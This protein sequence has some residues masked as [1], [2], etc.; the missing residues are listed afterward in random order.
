MLKLASRNVPCKEI[1]KA[2]ET[3]QSMPD[4]VYEQMISDIHELWLC[5]TINMELLMDKHASC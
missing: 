1:Y 2:K 5:K 4:R 3:T